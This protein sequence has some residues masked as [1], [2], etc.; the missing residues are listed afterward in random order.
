MCNEEKKSKIVTAHVVSAL[1]KL[2]FTQYVAESQAVER[3]FNESQVLLL[4]CY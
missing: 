4:D 3:E 2:R 1:G